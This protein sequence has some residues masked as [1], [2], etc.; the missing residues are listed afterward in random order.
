MIVQPTDYNDEYPPPGPA[1]GALNDFQRIVAQ[2]A[3]E[4]LPI[5]ALSPR[6]LSNDSP[7]GGWD[8]SGYQQSATYGGIEPP[9]GP[10][11]WIMRDFS[12][13]VFCWVGNAMSVE[14][15]PGQNQNNNL[16]LISRLAL[17][18]SV[19]DE[20]HKW[21]V[22]AAKDCFCGHE[23][24]PTEYIYLASTRSAAGRPTIDLLGN[25]LRDTEF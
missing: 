16:C 15:S 2:A 13:P 5:I 18:Q 19:M 14:R 6:F 22:Y 21:R 20:G 25:I 17:T 11:P 23:R 9:K 10:T 4:E 1:V 7:S 12:P 24:E 8:Q 3:I